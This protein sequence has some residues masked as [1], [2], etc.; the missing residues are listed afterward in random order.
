MRKIFGSIAA[1][2]AASVLFVLPVGAAA[3]PGQ[4]VKAV[5]VEVIGIVETKSGANRDVAIHQVL[6]NNFDFPYMGR[7]ALG[8][9]WNEASE[10]QRARFLAALEATESHAY[11]ERLGKL[12]GYV[13]TV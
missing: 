13:L 2:V 7:T 4:L 3:D 11:S 10:Q 12:S 6:R 8:T 5:M 9:H 1:A